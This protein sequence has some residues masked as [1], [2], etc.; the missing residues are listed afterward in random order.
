M[1][2]SFCALNLKGVLALFWAE[3]R[4]WRRDVVVSYTMLV[5]LID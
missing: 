1:S 4:C 5:A 2:F 3:S